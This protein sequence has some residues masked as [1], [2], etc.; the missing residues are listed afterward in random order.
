M[1]LG[2]GES[3]LLPSS[4]CKGHVRIGV[5]SSSPAFCC[6]RCLNSSTYAGACQRQSTWMCSELLVGWQNVCG[7]NLTQT[8][9]RKS[10][11]W[12]L[13]SKPGAG[14]KYKDIDTDTNTKSD[15]TNLQEY[16]SGPLLKR[17]WACLLCV[18][19]KSAL[20]VV[21]IYFPFFPWDRRSFFNC[22]FATLCFCRTGV[23]YACPL[24]THKV[25]FQVVLPYQLRV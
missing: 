25:I 22:F 4:R 12:S 1:A 24:P 7:M 18:T 3:T 16:L 17:L 11:A 8:C 13:E 6:R 10:A 9:C 20:S 14:D 23:D 15:T 2:R 21:L 19:E 5:V